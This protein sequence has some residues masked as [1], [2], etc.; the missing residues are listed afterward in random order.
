MTKAVKGN[1]VV[2]SYV[3]EYLLGQYCATDDEDVCGEC[4]GT[5]EVALSFSDVSSTSATLNFTSNALID[6]FNFTVDGVDFKAARYFDI[7]ANN[8]KLDKLVPSVL[9]AR[10]LCKTINHLDS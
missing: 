5:C 2:P 10:K 8:W 7:T 1:S 6:G 4:G 3:L 9:E